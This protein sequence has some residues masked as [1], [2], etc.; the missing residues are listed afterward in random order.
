MSRLAVAAPGLALSITA[1]RR[2]DALDLLIGG[3]LDLAVGFFP[4]PGDSFSV[5]RLLDDDYSVVIRPDALPQDGTVS[6]GQYLS[7][8][9]IIVSPGG[10][11]HG[12]VDAALHL[13]GQTR[14]VVAAFPQFLPALAAVA[15]TGCFVTMPSSVARKWAPT[16]GLLVARS[17]VALRRLTIS[18]VVHRRNARD[19]R[20]GW[21]T[22]QLQAVAYAAG[23]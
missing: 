7:A 11:L 16:F 2:Q 18:A 14:R 19:P 10:G 8:R 21:I 15:E 12:L 17:P 1:Q 5:T 4:G 13:Q 23:L 20:L 22:A 6:L 9:H 3:T